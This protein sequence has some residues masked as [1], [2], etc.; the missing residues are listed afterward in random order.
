M[1]QSLWTNRNV[2]A[3][4]LAGFFSDVCQEPPLA[5]LPAFTV[6]VAGEANAAFYLGIAMGLSEAFSHIFKLVFGWLSPRVKYRK[7]LVAGGY[8]IE[9]VFMA[10]IGLATL[11]WHIVLFRATSRIGKGMRTPARDTMLSASV[12]NTY[13]ATAFGIQRM[14]DT[15][16]AVV[17]ISLLMWTI[18]WVAQR[19]VF[20][21][22]VVP[23]L[24]AVAV[25]MLFSYDPRDEHYMLHEW[26]TLTHMKKLPETF[27]KL[28]FIIAL[29]GITKIHAV[30]LLLRQYHIA[31]ENGLLANRYVMI[32]YLCYN[33]ARSVYGYIAGRVG[34][35]LGRSLVLAING[36]LLFGVA[37][38]FML[39][40]RPELWMSVPSFALLG[41]SDTTVRTLEKSLV[42]ELLPEEIRDVGYGILFFIKG[43][44]MLAAGWIIG[45][46]WSVYTSFHA[47]VYIFCISS[48]A[49]I[50]LILRRLGYLAS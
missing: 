32:V 5:I 23:A 47:L 35:R 41:M 48:M 2:I 15:F 9:G 36:Y 7:L 42:A 43:V 14:S 13:Y 50:L 16:G 6:A 33:I 10:L 29:F 38:G 17:G 20:F 30:V 45:S 39:F 37:T 8:L 25:I 11:G 21:L 34:D 3:F 1:A 4:S 28:L 12:P 26:W 44:A 40:S 22:S 24:M 46:I 18:E 19:T 31:Q 27:W 49:A